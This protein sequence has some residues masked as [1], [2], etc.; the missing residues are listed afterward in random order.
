[1]SLSLHC[2]GGDLLDSRTGHPADPAPTGQVANAGGG[3]RRFLPI[4]VLAAQ[5]GKQELDANNGQNEQDQRSPDFSL[6]TDVAVVL[7]CFGRCIDRGD[8]G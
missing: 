1:M 7:L 6:I 5:R 2:F 8:L 4:D 3:R